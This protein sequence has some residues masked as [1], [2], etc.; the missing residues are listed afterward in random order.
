M[1]SAMGLLHTMHCNPEYS[2]QIVPVDYVISHIIVA[3][4]DTAKRK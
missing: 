2:A 3:A 1:G 4:W